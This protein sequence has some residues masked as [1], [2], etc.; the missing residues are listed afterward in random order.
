MLTG[1]SPRPT[2]RS[3][4]PVFRAT[5]WISTLPATQVTPRRLSSGLVAA[6][7]NAIMSSMPVS[8]SMMRGRGSGWPEGSASIGRLW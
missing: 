4:F 6:M 2:M 5:W 7:S 1:T 8:T 3:S